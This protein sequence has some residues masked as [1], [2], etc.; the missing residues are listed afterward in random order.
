MAIDYS[1]LAQPKGPTRKK[2]KARKDRKESAVKKSV[3]EECVDRDGLCRFATFRDEVIEIV[4][5]C[6]GRSEWMHLGD[7]KRARTR[8]MDP[9][10]RHTTEGSLMGCTKHHADYDQGRLAVEPVNAEKGAKGLLRV[11]NGTASAEI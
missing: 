11:S 1:I 5:P 10:V 7:K 2:L 6:R 9:E 8:G 3:R 4:G